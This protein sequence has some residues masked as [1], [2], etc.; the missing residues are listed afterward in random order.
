MF[1]FTSDGYLVNCFPFNGSF[2]C[3]VVV[4]VNNLHTIPCITNC[5]LFEILFH[6]TNFGS[7]VFT[8]TTKKGNLANFSIASLPLSFCASLTLAEN[9]S[10]LSLYVSEW[11][12][13]MITLNEYV[14]HSLISFRFLRVSPVSRIGCIVSMFL[15]LSDWRWIE[16][17][18]T[19][20]S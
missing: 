7:T 11:V 15:L 9:K 20:E 8:T 2:R 14:Y 1:L 5:N 16:N 4:V 19:M 10:H 13:H 12:C 3:F 18:V 17:G 6:F